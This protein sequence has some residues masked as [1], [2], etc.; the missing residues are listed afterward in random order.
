MINLKGMLSFA[1]LSFSLAVSSLRG[2][3]APLPGASPAHVTAPDDLVHTGANFVG[4]WTGQ[5]EYRDY[6]SDERVFLPTWLTTKSSSDGR[7][8]TFAYVYDDG[9]TKVVRESSVLTLFPQANSATVS[10][11]GEHGGDSYAVVGFDEFSK[12]NRGKLTLTGKGTENN[13]P[14]DVRISIM[15]GR[16]LF[17]WRKETR[18]AGSADE[19]RFRDG[20]TFTRALAPAL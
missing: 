8:L 6:Q 4:D 2:Q 9:P 15:L 13:K 19:F 16:N 1:L 3:A 17:T 12:K 14:V 18:A 20:Y 10:S 7:A 5:L 11:G